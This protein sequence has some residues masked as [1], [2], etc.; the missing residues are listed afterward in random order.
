MVAR[1]NERSN[2]RLFRSVD[3]DFAL[4]PAEVVA[5]EIFADLTNPGLY[6][7][8]EL[9]PTQNDAWA[10]DLLSRLQHACG[11]RLPHVWSVR[12]DKAT[13]PAL[14][15]WFAEGRKLSVG[16][17][18]GGRARHH[19]RLHVVVLMRVR[20]GEEMLLPGDFVDLVPGDELLFAGQSEARRAITAI[21][22]AEAPRD[23]ALLGVDRPAG[24]VWR[25]LARPTE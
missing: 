3:L 19:A 7:F 9:V 25:R 13:A 22:A 14:A 23:L 15:T 16:A 21:L 24:W 4:I 20:G 2:R 1:Q 11:E 8:L 18:L 5:R 17:L 12:L 6:R 10:E